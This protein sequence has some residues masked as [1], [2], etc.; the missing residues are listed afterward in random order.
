MLDEVEKAHRD[1]FNV[2]LQ[3]LDDGRLTDGQGRTVDFRNTVIIMTSNLGSHVIAELAPTGDEERMRREVMGVLK[4]EFLPEFLNRIDETIIFHPLGKQELT[5]IV[6][7]QLRRL[8]KQMAEAN[9]TVKVTDAARK[10]LA[11]EGYDPAYG[12]RPLKRVIQQRLANRLAS[13]ILEGRVAESGTVSIDWDRA[14]I[15][16]FTPV[17]AAQPAGV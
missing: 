8:E 2:L 1:V 14:G 13:E 3:V 10:Q 17:G 5:K 16:R 11:E 15:H 6:D 4:S 9:I 12:A 7:I